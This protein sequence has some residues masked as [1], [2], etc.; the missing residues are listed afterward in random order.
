MN[1][2]NDESHSSQNNRWRRRR[3][4]RLRRPRA[5]ARPFALSIA[6]GVAIGIAYALLYGPSRGAYVD[7]LMAGAALGIPWWGLINIIALPV[8][9]SRTP[10]WDADQMRAQVPALVGWVV[11]GSMMGLLVQVITDL[12]HEVFGPEPPPIDTS[13]LPKTRVVILGGGFA[14]M[15]TALSLEEQFHTNPASEPLAHQRHQRS[16]LY[17]DAR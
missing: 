15:Q 8:F 5:Y 10:E 14:G 9:A 17:S 13:T 11:Y 3:R 2:T 7:N 16:P 12:L 6:F 1:A 4:F